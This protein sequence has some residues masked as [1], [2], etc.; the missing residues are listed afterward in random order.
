MFN[1]CCNFKEIFVLLNPNFSETF[2]IRICQIYNPI[3]VE[4]LNANGIILKENV[5]ALVANPWRC[6][7]TLHNQSQPETSEHFKHSKT[8]VWSD[9]ELIEKKEVVCLK[10]IYI[11]QLLLRV[12]TKNTGQPLSMLN[13]M[14]Y[15]Q[16]SNNLFEGQSWGIRIFGRSGCMTVK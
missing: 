4:T 8:N 11:I 14:T 10:V 12:I 7:L 15:N 16:N 13:V 1:P 3:V 6:Y 5:S 2:Q 9:V